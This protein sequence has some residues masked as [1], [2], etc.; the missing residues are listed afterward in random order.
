[1]N[2]QI[3]KRCIMIFPEF[4]NME[5]IDKIR[6]KY[7]PFANNVGP[8]VTLVFPFDSSIKS[9]DLKEYLKEHLKDKK[10]FEI[11][12]KD[13]IKIDDDT[14]KFLFLTVKDGNEKVKELNKL[15]Y[16]G[17]LKKYKPGFLNTVE[18]MPHMTLGK[19]DSSEKLNIAYENIKNMQDE[20]K[21]TVKKVSVEIIDENM[22]SI[23][24]MEIDLKEK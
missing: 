8:H 4:E 19:F 14:G 21:S 24:E 2:E 6:E 18:F 1:M 3:L 10:T 13:I 23:I 22:D 20:F 11:R 5:I 15:L 9:E 12:L 7:D 17:I 16:S